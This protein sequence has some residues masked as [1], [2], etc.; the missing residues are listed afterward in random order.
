MAAILGNGP[1]AKNIHHESDDLGTGRVRTAAQSVGRTPD[2]IRLIAVSKRQPF[3]R[4]EEAY[5]LGLRDFGENTAQGLAARVRECDAAG[6]RGIRWHFVGRLQ[7]NKRDQL[8]SETMS[9]S[10]LSRWNPCM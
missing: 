7:R 10:H 6:L 8:C 5:R 2:E 4:L 9:H 1:E 3:E